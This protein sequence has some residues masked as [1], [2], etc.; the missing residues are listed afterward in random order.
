MEEFPERNPKNYVWNF[1]YAN[2]EDSRLFPPKPDP[3]YGLTINFSHPRLWVALLCFFG[4]FGFIITMIL[5]GN[6]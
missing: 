2:K 5:I 6:N 3:D 1:F 4:F